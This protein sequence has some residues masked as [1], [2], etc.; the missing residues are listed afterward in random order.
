MLQRASPVHFAVVA[1]AVVCVMAWVA[2]AGP[3]PF[4]ER[5]PDADRDVIL[6]PWGLRC[7]NQS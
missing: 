6:R 1:F 4:V 2:A 3:P 7:P 5:Q